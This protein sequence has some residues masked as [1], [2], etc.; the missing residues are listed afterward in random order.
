M[1]LVK[2]K[3]KLWHGFPLHFDEFFNEDFFPVTKACNDGMKNSPSVNIKDNEDNITLDLA[4]PGLKK[5]DFHIEINENILTISSKKEL[6]KET[7]S[8]DKKYTR[9]E[10]SYN[11][12]KRSFNLLEDTFKTDKI[13]ANYVDGILSVI[14]PKKEAKKKLIRTISVN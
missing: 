9:K 6:E 13:K 8:E 5:N 3:P 4:A 2:R 11:Y 14:I 12:F 7:Y 1:N 10:F